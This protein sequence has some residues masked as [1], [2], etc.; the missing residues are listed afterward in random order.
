MR[1]FYQILFLILLSLMAPWSYGQQKVS[2]QD[3]ISIFLIFPGHD[4]TAANTNVAL[5]ANA[6]LMG[7]R[8]AVNYQ[9]CSPGS[10]ALTQTTVVTDSILSGTDVKGP[11]VGWR[12]DPRFTPANQC[13]PGLDA[14]PTATLI[15]KNVI[16]L[17]TSSVEI[18][19]GYSNGVVGWIADNA[20]QDCHP[21]FDEGVQKVQCTLPP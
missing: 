7:V 14:S 6:R 9:P 5:P 2:G 4:S 17:S 3:G 16:P 8:S 1:R 10:A 13:I 21:V 15:F 12:L 18:L 19:Y 11:A 20:G